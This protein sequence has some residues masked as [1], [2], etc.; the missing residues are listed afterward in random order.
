[1]SRKSKIVIAIVCIV[2]IVGI[3]LYVY[4]VKKGKANVE[5]QLNETYNNWLEK[6][7]EENSVNQENVIDDN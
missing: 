5:A 6:I 7:A 1:M 2:V 4:A 3:G